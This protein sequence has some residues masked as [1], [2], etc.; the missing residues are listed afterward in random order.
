MH[1]TAQKISRFYFLDS[2]RGFFAITVAFSHFCPHA[3]VIWR[4]FL[5]YGTNIGVFGFFVLSSF[6]LT[7][8]LFFEFVIIH[9]ETDKKF[10]KR[11]LFLV[12][13]AK[14]FIR[15][16]F[17]V[18]PLF[19][20]IFIVIKYG[21]SYTRD[22]YDFPENIWHVL[23]LYDTGGSIPWTIHIEMTYYICIPFICLFALYCRKRFQFV[24][25]V[26]LFIFAVYA[27][28]QWTS[29]RV[30]GLVSFTCFRY[31]ASVFLSGSGAALVYYWFEQ[32]AANIPSYSTT[33]FDQVRE[34]VN[35]TAAVRKS[36]YYDHNIFEHVLSCRAR[37]ILDFCCYLLSAL[38]LIFG[39][40]HWKLLSFYDYSGF[41]SFYNYPG[42]HWSLVLLLALISRGSFTNMLNNKFFNYAG[43]VSYSIYL[44]HFIC[45]GKL[46]NVMKHEYFI[47]F[48]GLFIYVCLIMFVSTVTYYLIEHPG[49][50]I[51][52]QLCYYIDIV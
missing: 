18:Y 12:C 25:I 26:L 6:L 40:H 30:N 13:I 36:H 46:L 32:H 37:K 48:E 39:N 38:F 20:F 50:W 5:L 22:I 8:R 27:D 3:D 4:T 45:L 42:Y 49:M 41:T 35:Q 11:K 44:T 47:G 15:R 2:F 28:F 33:S 14:F 34:S 29:E 7:Y 52:N 31:W 43:K 21:P 1:S 51:G 10:S 17:R 24:P 16:I 19:I 9:S 23:F